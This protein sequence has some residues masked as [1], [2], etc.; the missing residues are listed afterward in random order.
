MKKDVL[1]ILKFNWQDTG[2]KEVIKV[3]DGDD[4]ND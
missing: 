3:V 4:V 1:N 2:S